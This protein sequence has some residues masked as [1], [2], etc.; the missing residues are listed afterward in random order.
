MHLI[1]NHFNILET[2]LACSWLN[3]SQR[4][5]IF[6]S[7]DMAAK[8]ISMLTEVLKNVVQNKLRLDSRKHVT[9]ACAVIKFVKGR[10]EIDTKLYV[11]TK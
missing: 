7:R 3:Y 9:F 4:V 6:A 2:S 8:N 1:S 10:E 5:F 11:E